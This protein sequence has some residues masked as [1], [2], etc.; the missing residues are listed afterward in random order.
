MFG[1]ERDKLVKSL[2]K[3]AVSRCGYLGNKCDCK[4][5]SEDDKSNPE[6]TGCPEIMMAAQIISNMTTQE[7]FSLTKRADIT[8]SE[9]PSS[10]LDA[11]SMII[12]LKKEKLEKMREDSQ[13]HMAS[14]EAKK[15]ARAN[16][17]A[18]K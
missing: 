12:S 13:K 3:L 8:I 1:I 9:A 17:K 5:M 18:K 7:F 14:L 16:K 6:A 15:A 2:C 11:S 10:V 4:Y